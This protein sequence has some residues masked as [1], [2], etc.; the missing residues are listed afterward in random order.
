MGDYDNLSP[1]AT[2]P[3]SNSQTQDY[4]VIAGKAHNNHGLQDSHDNLYENLE[5]EECGEN[6]KGLVNSRLDV[7]NGATINSTLPQVGGSVPESKGRTSNLYDELERP[8]SGPGAALYNVLEEPYYSNNQP[9][10]YQSL[11]RKESDMYQPLQF[12][13]KK[14]KK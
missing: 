11:E 9:S 7:P 8:L 10:D 12:A 1:K 3:K 6:N 4:E 14:K 13:M 5:K 2:K